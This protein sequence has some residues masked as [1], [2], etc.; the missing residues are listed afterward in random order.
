MAKGEGGRPLRAI[1]RLPRSALQPSRVRG[2]IALQGVEVSDDHLQEIVEVVGNAP[3]GFHLLRLS[4]RLLVALQVF[5]ALED[6]LFQRGV[7]VDQR[8]LGW[9][10]FRYA[11]ATTL[12]KEEVCKPE[13]PLVDMK[14][15]L[16]IIQVKDPRLTGACRS[17][18]E[19][20]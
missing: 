2:N 16:V 1:H 8:F 4:Y 17:A 15:R 18:Q 20:V 19:F 3:H 14:K 13:W 9:L 5:G 10:A 11:V 12:R 6:L 7:Q